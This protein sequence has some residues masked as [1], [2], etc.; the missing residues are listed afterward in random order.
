MTSL[1]VKNKVGER[2][3]SYSNGGFPCGNI[4]LG[5]RLSF[6]ARIRNRLSEDQAT[7]MTIMFFTIEM[8]MT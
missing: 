6:S 1:L 8:Q 3:D 4:A 2:P 5:E 7:T